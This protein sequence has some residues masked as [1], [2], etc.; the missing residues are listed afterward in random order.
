MQISKRK[1]GPGLAWL[2]AV[3]AILI[4]ATLALQLSVPAR[5]TDLWWH[6][7]LGRH[8]LDSGSLIID[9]AQFSWTPATSYHVYNSWLTDIIL[10]RVNEW[11]GTGG[12]IAL[13]FLVYFGI[14]MLAWRH[15][16]RLGIA[17][18]PLSWLI[19][20][21]SLTVIWVANEIKPELFSLGFMSIVVWLYYHMRTQGNQAWRLPYLYPFLLVLWINMHGAF[22]IAS[23]FFACVVAGELLN[24]RFSPDQAMPKKLRKHFLIA[25]GLCIPALLLNPFTYELPLEIMGTLLKNEVAGYSRISAYLPTFIFN[26][27]PHY[28]LDYLIA[29]M[30]LFVFLLWQKLKL[31][32][33]D[34]VVILSFVAYCILFIQMGRTTAYLAPVFLFAALDLLAEKERSWAWPVSLSGQILL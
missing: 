1:Q 13:R 34:W 22:F 3:L 9:H 15:A 21:I 28:M 19:I 31:R 24:A 11:L 23:L 29:A 32:Q 10:Y 18:N 4:M 17:G 8:I 14:V 30:V 33:T 2:S 27:P 16:A 7:A 25:L 26:F 20:L 5:S 12:L 6:M